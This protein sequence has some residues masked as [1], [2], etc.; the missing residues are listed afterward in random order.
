MN[1][2]IALIML[3]LV[4]IGTVNAGSA[5]QKVLYRYTGKDTVIK[6]G[7][8]EL[9]LRKD[10]VVYLESTAKL[11]KDSLLRI[12]VGEDS[13]YADFLKKS[14]A[15]DMLFERSQTKDT[16]DII[17][18]NSLAGIANAA[19]TDKNSAYISVFSAPDSIVMIGNNTAKCIDLYVSGKFM[20]TINRGTFYVFNKNIFKHDGNIL[21]FCGDSIVP[22]QT[23]LSFAAEEDNICIWAFCGIIILVAVIITFSFFVWKYK[24]KNNKYNGAKE[25]GEFCICISEDKNFNKIF[26]A[27]GKGDK[28]SKKKF[29]RQSVELPQEY[30]EKY[31]SDFVDDYYS[32]IQTRKE[33]KEYVKGICDDNIHLIKLPVKFQTEMPKEEGF[34]KIKINKNKYFVK[35]IDVPD[36]SISR[37]GIWDEI[38]DS[39]TKLSDILI[40]NRMMDAQFTSVEE[41]DNKVDLESA[42]KIINDLNDRIVLLRKSTETEINDLTVRKTELEEEL[43]NAKN[44]LNGVRSEKEKFEHKYKVCN[45]AL[46]DEKKKKETAEEK[47]AELRQE[48]DSEK[49]ASKDYNDLLVFY[50]PCVDVA[51]IAM[52]IIVAVGKAEAMVCDL[53]EKYKENGHDIDTFC[54]YMER[55]AQK[56]RK[57]LKKLNDQE[58]LYN[59]ELRLL[60]ETGLAKKSG[61]I[62]KMMTGKKHEEKSGVFI[63]RLYND[64][65]SMYVGP[66]IIMVEEYAYLLEAMVP[67][68]DISITKRFVEFSKEIQKNAKALNYEICYARPIT[69]ISNY[70]NVK[71]EE[72]VDAGDRFAKDTIFEVIEMAVNY[73]S[74]RLT[75][76]VSVQR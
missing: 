70:S 65:F 4:Y 45:T 12:Y 46:I 33:I 75:T 66:S 39:I 15:F 9:A 1:K 35:P 59:A 50:K 58:I 19:I 48:L 27:L 52:A 8:S 6:S 24:V 28:S 11:D 29:I 71:N 76:K 32:E 47:V 41:E 7:S 72:Y 40:M 31:V 61:W 25:G 21:T 42:N 36:I 22:K 73:G 38:T 17:I 57:S 67:D 14:T 37:N 16:I 30:D 20:A 23:T 51:K 74:N 60:S 56:Y 49:Q 54:Y 5:T 55:I 34:I 18:Q 3:T 43:E 2:I 44:D 26:S 13:P 63:N 68:V 62:D 10:F 53:Y 64:Y 69:P